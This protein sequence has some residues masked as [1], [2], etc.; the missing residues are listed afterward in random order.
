MSVAPPPMEQAWE[1]DFGTGSFRRSQEV[2]LLSAKQR[3][4]ASLQKSP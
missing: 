4:A 3:T 1:G 2:S